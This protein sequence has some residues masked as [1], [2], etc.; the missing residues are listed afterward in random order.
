MANIN[1]TKPNKIE[2]F[3]VWCSKKY[4]LWCKSNFP[5]IE[6]TFEALDTYGLICKIVQYLNEIKQNLNTTEDNVQNIYNFVTNYFD[7]LDVQNEINNKLDEMVSSGVL[8]EIISNYLNSKAVFGF[9]NVEEMKNAENLI[10]GSFAKTLGYYSINDNGS[11]TYKIR[12]RTV[13][14]IIDNGKIILLNNENLVAELIVENNTITPEQF[15]CYGDA[16][17]DDTIQLQKALN[18]GY[19]LKTKGIYNITSKIDIN[20]SIY[21]EGDSYIS[22]SAVMELAVLISSR[23]VIGRTFNVNVDAHG[24]SGIAIG[25]GQPRKCKLNLNVA[26]SGNTGIDMRY[27]LKNGNGE[28]EISCNVIGNKNGT[29]EVGVLVNNF[30]S[31]FHAIVTQD[32]KY[33]VKLEGA[34]LIATSVHS[35]LSKEV[36]EKLW[37]ESAVIYNTSYYH[38]EIKWLYQDSVK[39]GVTGVGPYGHIDFFEYNNTLGNDSLDDEMINVYV[40]SGPTRLTIN[41]FVND[42]SDYKRI[43]YQ[44][45]MNSSEF[46]VLIKNGVDSNPNLI[47]NYPLFTDVNEAPQYCSS[48]VLYDVPNLPVQQNGF[49][50][51]EVIGSVIVQTFYGEGFNDVPQ[52]YVR[53]RKIGDS[54]WSQW[55][56]FRYY[57]A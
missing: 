6:N 24:I 53:T 42:R 40:P 23:H 22:V 39:Y 14:D 34:E 35:W 15:G 26:N 44:V 41:R 48:Y 49:L 28:N 47:K 8:Q 32:C 17:H 57:S 1:Y 7:N 4:P 11:A 31:I 45:P 50:K 21:M 36:Y 16:E 51:S 56:K 20:N 46:G 33:G 2:D 30:D 37:S 9:N 29:T 54:S 18:S 3:S 12:N 52:F 25:V 43:K 13:D 5:F 10:E 19:D 38:M 27:G 55:G